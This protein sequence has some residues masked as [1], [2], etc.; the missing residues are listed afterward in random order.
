[1]NDLFVTSRSNTTATWSTPVSA[2]ELSSSAADD[3]P[4][5]TADGLTCLFSSNRGGDYDIY[6]ASRPARTAPFSTPVLLAEVAT[7]DD[8]TDPWLSPDG[9]LL[10]FT[11]GVSTARDIYAATR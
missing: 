1:M 6:I 7:A 11:R 4:F 9:H 3:E 5:L 8:E 2:P 10:L